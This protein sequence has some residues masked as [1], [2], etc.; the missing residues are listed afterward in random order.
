MTSRWATGIDGRP[1][2][3]ERGGQWG[4]RDGRGE[5]TGIDGRPRLGERGGHFWA[6]A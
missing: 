1:R 6:P 2:L 3:G 4:G 5:S